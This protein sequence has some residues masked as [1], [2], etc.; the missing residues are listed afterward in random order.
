MLE[1]GETEHSR[2]VSFVHLCW[3]DQPRGTK[4]ARWV[5]IDTRRDA[6]AR[7]RQASPRHRGRKCVDLQL[8]LYNCCYADGTYTYYTLPLLSLVPP[9]Q[10]L[11]MVAV[12]YCTYCTLCVPAFARWLANPSLPVP[13]PVPVP[14]PTSR[15]YLATDQ[16]PF[17]YH[18]S[19]SFPSHTP[20]PALPVAQLT[21]TSR[22]CVSLLSL[23]ITN[24]II[25]DIHLPSS[26]ITL[27]RLSIQLDHAV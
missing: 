14:F 5:E 4:M 21:R 27:P 23:F 17:L 20:P 8:M 11:S 9:P 2:D 1:K 6:S 24:A 12:F 22:S 25:D 18:T 16:V 3:G 26:I 10:R 15:R 19:P 13:V 7:Q